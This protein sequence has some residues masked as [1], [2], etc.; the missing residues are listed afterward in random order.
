MTGPRQPRT[1]SHPFNTKI[2][3]GVCQVVRVIS[4]CQFQVYNIHRNSRERLIISKY[5]MWNQMDEW[6]HAEVGLGDYINCGI[7]H[8]CL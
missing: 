5:P 6:K 8:D 7:N 3:T 1:C 4:P 2:L